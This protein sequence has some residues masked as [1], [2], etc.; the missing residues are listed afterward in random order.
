[1]AY[2]P[3]FGANIITAARRLHDYRAVAESSGDGALRYTSDLLRQYQ[4]M[5]IKDLIRETYVAAR[6]Q[7][8]KILP[9]MVSESADITLSGGGVGTL[10]TGVWIVLE[11]A[12]SDYSIYYQKI[13]QNPLKVRANRDALMVP[14]ATKPFWYQIGTTIQILPTN[15]TGPIHVWALSVPPDTVLDT[16]G[17]IPI[18][19]AWDADIVRRMV[20]YG[21]QDAK[22]SIAI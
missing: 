15:V 6:D 12:K 13:D 3:R 22:S 2:S 8:D 9:E 20:E 16:A 21:V 10:P 17:E 5:A 11:A 1:M 7:V 19:S 14:S 18:S 4:N